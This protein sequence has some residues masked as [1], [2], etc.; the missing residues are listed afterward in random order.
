MKVPI[1][2][3]TRLAKKKGIQKTL[4]I[5]FETDKEFKIDKN[6]NVYTMG[7]VWLKI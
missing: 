3:K 2:N 1:S 7:N 4:A 6:G 5:T